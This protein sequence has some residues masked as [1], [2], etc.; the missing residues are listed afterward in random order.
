MPSY[1]TTAA[2]SFASSNSSGIASYKAAIDNLK[3]Y[4]K[5]DSLNSNNESYAKIYLIAFLF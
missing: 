5:Q 2:G 3:D 1:V 4:I